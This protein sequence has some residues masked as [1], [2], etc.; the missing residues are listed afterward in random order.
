MLK[1]SHKR[2]K[3]TGL[4]FFIGYMLLILY[5]AE[6]RKYFDIMGIEENWKRY[7]H[8]IRENKLPLL[9]KEREEEILQETDRILREEKSLFS[10]YLYLIKM[11]A[12]YENGYLLYGNERIKQKILE[13]MKMRVQCAL[14]KEI[15]EAKKRMEPMV[16]PPISEGNQANIKNLKENIEILERQLKGLIE[17][18]GDL[19]EEC[20]LNDKA[21]IKAELNAGEDERGP[22]DYSWNVNVLYSVALSCFS[23]DL[24]EYFCVG[25]DPYYFGHMVSDFT[26]MFEPYAVSV[27]FATIYAN[28]FLED[29]EQGYYKK[30][31]IYRKNGS[32]MVIEEAMTIVKDMTSLNPDFVKREKQ[33]LKKV[34][35]YYTNK[36]IEDVNLERHRILKGNSIEEI[37]KDMGKWADLT[38]TFTFDEIIRQAMLEIYERIG[39]KEDIEDIKR[40]GE[41]INLDY[42]VRETNREG[43]EEM[44]E[45]YLKRVKD[46]QER[47]NTLI[48]KLSR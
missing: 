7:I 31:K 11:V 6:G 44:K 42:P 40:L 23:G 12:D 39:E 47:I 22:G 41:G 43:D 2:I 27:S 8:L 3:N 36:K 10:G 35:L 33:R 48:E 4:I 15:R 34:L 25:V 13:L 1:R 46:L 24:Y 20:Y 17:K 16:S 29:L 30:G 26:Y 28:R 9:E 45:R 21:E 37:E 32:C 14:K 38:L 5:W 19:C 18:D